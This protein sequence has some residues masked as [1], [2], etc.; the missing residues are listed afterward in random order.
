[1]K[2][3]LKAIL[4]LFFVSSFSNLQAQKL[5]VKVHPLP[6]PLQYYA[7]DFGVYTG[8]L[9]GFRLGIRSSS[10]DFGELFDNERHLKANIFVLDYVFYMGSSEE[11]LEG[12]YIGPY[13]KYRN[14]T[15][16]NVLRSNSERGGTATVN[17]LGGGFVLGLSPVFDSGLVLDFYF[18][19]GLRGEQYREYDSAQT[20]N[21]QESNPFIL[22]NPLDV[23]LGASI[24]YRF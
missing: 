1:M 12:F 9:G 4:L 8:D 15:Y 19:L 24:G 18:G 17:D 6:A 13:V 2:Y 10:L 14:R 22:T 23:R 11:P 16:T 3:M 21:Y 5:E 7:A 20:E